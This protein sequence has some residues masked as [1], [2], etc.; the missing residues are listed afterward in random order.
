MDV[1]VS[2]RRDSITQTWYFHF[3]R[4]KTIFKITHCWRNVWISKV[5]KR[6]HL[7]DIFLWVKNLPEIKYHIYEI[8]SLTDIAITNWHSYH[9][10]RILYT[11]SLVCMGT[12]IQAFCCLKLTGTDRQADGQVNLCIGRLR[13][14]K[15]AMSVFCQL[16]RVLL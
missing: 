1:Q 5:L 10:K 3:L 12:F 15:Y 9:T 8:V 2:R 13:L 6:A 16:F 4:K 7:A 11:S 14:Q